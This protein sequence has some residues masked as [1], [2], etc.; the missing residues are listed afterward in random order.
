MEATTLIYYTDDQ[1]HCYVH[2]VNTQQ[3]YNFS[4]LPFHKRDT[5][6]LIRKPPYESV[7]PYKP[8]P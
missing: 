3:F 1:G 7:D 2:P 6:Q 4:I 5:Y 8:N